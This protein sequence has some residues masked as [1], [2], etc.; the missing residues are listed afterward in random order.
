[1]NV[2]NSGG[3][4]VGPTHWLPL[5]PTDYFRASFGIASIGCN[6]LVCRRCKELVRHALAGNGRRYQC[7]CEEHV[8]LGSTH[9]DTSDESDP[10]PVPPW[11]CAGHPG[12]TPPGVVAGVEVAYS[13]GWSPIV[14]AHIVETSSLHPTIDRILGF[15]LTRIFQALESEVDQRALATAVGGRGSD[16]ALLVRQAVALFFVLNGHAP[17]L[18]GVLDAWRADPARYDAHPAA[19]GPDQLLQDNL[20]EAVAVRILGKARDAD[21]LLAT[22][23]WA[24]LRGSGLGVNLHLAKT[25][26]A[27]WAKEHVEAMFDLA[28]Q[29]W[30][31]IL[32]AI[33]IE[34]PMR[35]VPGLRRAIAGGH[36]TL[37]QVATALTEE[38]GVRAE[39]LV[40][41]LS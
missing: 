7:A 17:G 25:F 19:F 24:A 11:Q 4:V 8:E 2:C 38:Y 6:Q 28:P 26:D 20:L 29:D 36:A 27:D 34:F 33:H 10:N 22:W 32:R 5:E 41:A 1:M 3:Y 30:Y 15:T 21:A 39:P 14:G 9:L 37:E 12:F 23:R 35:L 18:E 16:P 31:R 40:A 13:L